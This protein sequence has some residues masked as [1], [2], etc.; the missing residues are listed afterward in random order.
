[1]QDN[2]MQLICWPVCFINN[3][4]AVLV[5][6]AYMQ[7]QALLWGHAPNAP[8]LDASKVASERPNVHDAVVLARVGDVGHAVIVLVDTAYHKSWWPQHAVHPG[9]HS[10]P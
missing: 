3:S 9:G 1:M 8:Y 6:M 7:K 10:K 4:I 2:C 5:P